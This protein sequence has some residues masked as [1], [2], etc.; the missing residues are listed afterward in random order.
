MQPMY[1]SNDLLEHE[2]HLLLELFHIFLL[3]RGPDRFLYGSLNTIHLIYAHVRTDVTT[4]S[5]V[6]TQ[7]IHIVTG[8]ISLLLEQS[9]YLRYFTDRSVH[10]LAHSI[11]FVGKLVDVGLCIV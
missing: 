4:A 3:R 6:L 7:C 1:L 9:L 2:I 8:R 10:T 5:E 11:G